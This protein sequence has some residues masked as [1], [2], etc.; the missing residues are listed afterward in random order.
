MSQTNIFISYLVS[1]PVELAEILPLKIS[2]EVE[3]TLL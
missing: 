1:S 2:I 3:F